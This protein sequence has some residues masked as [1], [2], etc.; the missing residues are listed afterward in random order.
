MQKGTF[1][2]A[3][4]YLRRAR[5]LFP[6]LFVTLAGSL[7]VGGLILVPYHLANFAQSLVFSIVPAA[8][9]LFWKDTGYFS[10][11]AIVKPLL[12]MWS[13]AVEEQFYLIWPSLL[14]ALFTLRRSWLSLTIL[15]AVGIGS[16]AYAEVKLAAHPSEVFFLTQYRAF[17]FIAGV[18]CVWL[19]NHRPK[20]A[21][22]CEISLAVGLAMIAYAVFT[23]S[24]NMAFPG[25]NV[26]PPVIGAML[27]IYAGSPHYLGRLL[28]NRVA[29]GV[30]LISYSLY[31]VHWPLLV[32][33][34]GT[35]VSR[36]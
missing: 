20:S 22:A 33:Q 5:R 23:Y 31:L 3:N 11:A 1:S 19:V 9:I 29:V 15:L 17:E 12:N 28:S 24:R 14:I 8:N 21:F 10:S 27:V 36:F 6:A 34:K 13:L 4:F 2:F 26:I 32:Q 30:G 18:L 35:S 7:A 16:L 25:L